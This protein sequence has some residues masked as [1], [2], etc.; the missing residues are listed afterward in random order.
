MSDALLS[1]EQRAALSS[2]LPA[3]T[4]KE[5]TLERE[6]T[7][8]TFLAGIE[9]VVEIAKAAEALDHHPDID[10][11]WRTLRMVLSTHSAGGLTQRDVDLAHLIDAIVGT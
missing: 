10:I 9:W 11:R 6:V 8:P 3:W 4:V 1:S 7:A 2:A 5:T